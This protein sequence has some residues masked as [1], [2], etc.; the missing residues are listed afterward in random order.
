MK[1][2]RRL[3]RLEVHR[4]VPFADIAARK[5]L[6]AVVARME[7]AVVA[8]GDAA[9]RL[10]ASPLERMVRRVLRGKADLGDALRGLLTARTP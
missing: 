2:A 3:S 10:D 1:L 4:A 6:G 9:D 7:A 5:Q 8:S